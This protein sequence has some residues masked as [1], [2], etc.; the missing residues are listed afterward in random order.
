MPVQLRRRPTSDS[1]AQDRQASGFNRWLSRDANA[2][3]FAC[4]LVTGVAALA[5]VV[6][7]DARWLAA[8]GHTI[9]SRGSIPSGVP[10]ASAPTSH[11]HN[12]IVLA[13]VLFHWL[14]AAFGDRGVML[15]QLLAVVGATAILLKDARAGGASAR[16]AGAAVL[17]AALGTVSALVIARVQLFSLA[18][19]PLLVALLRSEYRR[20]SRRIW[21]A[22]PLIALWSNLHGAVLLGVA[23]LFAYLIFARVRGDKAVA[24]GVALGAIVALCVTPAGISTL[25]YYHGVITNQAASRGTGLWEPLSL[26]KSLDDLMIV[27]ALIFAVQLRRRRPPVWELVAAIGLAAETIQASRSGVWLLFF[28]APPAAAG[29]RRLG[30]WTWIIPPAATLALVGLVVGLVRGPVPN[31]TS[32][33][34]IDRAIALS[35]GGSILASDIIGEQLAL[36]GGRI[37]VGNPIDAFSKRDQSIYLD[38]LTDRRGGR[39]ALGPQIRVVLVSAKTQAQQLMAGDPSFALAGRDSRSLLY[40]RV[41]G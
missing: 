34:L 20:P 31:Q 13:E 17:L 26:S 7:A 30:W 1:S 8:L 36:D 4:L 15:A 18:L 12:A 23:V 37:W 40:L 38:W 29:F 9:V 2:G 25:S 28:L 33:A 6:G 11:W 22:L 24:A 10:F 21:L 39:E 41:G 35:H 16:A 5:S 14:E 3:P 32:R 19:F 27:A